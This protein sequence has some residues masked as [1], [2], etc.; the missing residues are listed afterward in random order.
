MY[1]RP[2]RST[3][4]DT[5][6]PYTTLF[7]S[8]G[9]VELGSVGMIA[10]DHRARVARKLLGVLAHK[11]R[12]GREDEAVAADRRRGLERVELRGGGIPDGQAAI[13]QFVRLEVRAARDR[14][15]I[16]ILG[17]AEIGRASGRER[18]SQYG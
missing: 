6:F 7:R 5:L 16:V 17:K 15:S 9:G 18:V 4:T 13:E 10:R 11:G 12:R 1:R 3:R 14:M 2:P 8:F